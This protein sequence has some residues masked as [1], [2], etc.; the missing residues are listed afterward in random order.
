MEAKKY[1]AATCLVVGGAVIGALTT[2]LVVADERADATGS[3]IVKRLGLP[4]HPEAEGPALSAKGLVPAA[5]APAPAETRTTT[6]N[7]KDD[8][9]K[10]SPKV[11]FVRTD[12]LPETPP[13]APDVRELY[14]AD[15]VRA[16]GINDKHRIFG[17]RSKY[18]SRIQLFDYYG[19]AFHRSGLQPQPGRTSP[20]SWVPHVIRLAKAKLTP[21]E[22]AE[23]LEKAWSLFG[24]ESRLLGL[25]A[26][27]TQAVIDGMERSTRYARDVVAIEVRK[28][29][30]YVVRS[31]DDVDVRSLAEQLRGL[32]E[33]RVAMIAELN[34]D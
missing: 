32:E 27:R 2:T 4:G 9:A 29:K 20:T 16:A 24:E 14:P 10:G 1:L 21:E 7:K 26:R 23:Y 12:E 25:L 34:R 15:L 33:R 3:D 5:G 19:N 17:D 13:D 22:K 31:S 28:G 18:A 11:V 8:A 30:T 6:S